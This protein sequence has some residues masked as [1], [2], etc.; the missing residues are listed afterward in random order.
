MEENHRNSILGFDVPMKG[1]IIDKRQET[2]VEAFDV[3]NQPWRFRSA[4]Q[5]WTCDNR[6]KFF[7]SKPSNTV[8]LL[9]HTAEQLSMHSLREPTTA[10]ERHTKNTIA[11]LHACV[12]TSLCRAS[13]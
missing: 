13:F 4:R 8:R 2:V 5:V 3:Y 1:I 11:M 12:M 9:W 10:E 7:V 6:T